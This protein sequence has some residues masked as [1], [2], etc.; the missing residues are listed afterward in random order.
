MVSLP[1]FIIYRR[2]HKRFDNAI[3]ELDSRHSLQISTLDS[4]FEKKISQNRR[5]K[6]VSQLKSSMSDAAMY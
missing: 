1:Q 5:Y 6:P 3:M 4:H 2:I